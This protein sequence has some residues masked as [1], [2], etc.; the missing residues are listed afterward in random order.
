MLET[1]ET[2]SLA[3]F[4]AKDNLAWWHYCTRAVL[5]LAYALVAIRRAGRRLLGKWSSMDFVVSIMI[6]SSLGRAMTGGAELW[7][8]LAAVTLLLVLH[9]LLAQWVARSER[10]DIWISGKP[11]VLAENGRVDTN[12]MRRSGVS[13]SDLEEA[14][15]SET[16]DDLRKT[17]RVVLETSGKISVVRED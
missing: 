17:R 12:A 9:A 5:I 15:R 7:A 14:L 1:A 2:W 13:M 3:L 4:G 10:A 16:I 11:V 6:A 8:T